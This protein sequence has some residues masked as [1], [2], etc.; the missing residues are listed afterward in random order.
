LAKIGRQVLVSPGTKECDFM[1][2]VSVT[3]VG[4]GCLGQKGMAGKWAREWVRGKSQRRLE[5]Q[6]RWFGQVW[7]LGHQRWHPSPL[8]KKILLVP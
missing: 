4:M 5:I 2:S 3:P 1:V 8:F 6:R 7:D